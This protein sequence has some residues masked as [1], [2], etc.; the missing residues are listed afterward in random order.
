MPYGIANRGGPPAREELAALLA[1]A[2][3]AGVAWIDAARAYGESE[4]RIGELAAGDP[5]WRIAT[6]L[7][8]DVDAGADLAECL[9]RAD[10][11]LEASRRALRRD[12][13]DLLLLHRAR[14]R[15]AFG[16][17]LFEH[18]LRRREQGWLRA[19]GASAASPEEAFGLLEDPQVEALQVAASLLDRRLA[20]AGFFERAAELGRRV[21]ARSVFLQGVAHL[22][23]GALPAGLAGLARPLALVDDWAR[24]R[25]LRRADA[26][27]LYARECLDVP[28]VLGCETA[29]QLRGDLAAWRSL[30]VPAGELR[31]L[32]RCLGPVPGALLD[33]SRWP[34]RADRPQAEA[35]QPSWSSHSRR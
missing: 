30:E 35:T 10:A 18:L 3:R 6:K 19:L 17:A 4:A 31:E 22:G 5:H 12:T 11:S 7:A 25:G 9:A 33:P 24:A 20:E 13:L 15:S 29:D 21:F 32:A 16:G 1:E 23:V 8:P 14:H 26:F 2:R 27:L 28:V 34:A